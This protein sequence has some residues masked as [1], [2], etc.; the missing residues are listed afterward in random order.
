MVGLIPLFATEVVDQ[1]LLANVPRFR[2][3]LREHKGGSF[4]GQLRL[5]LSGL[6]ERARRAPAGA[7][8]PHHAAA[9]PRAPARRGRVPVALR[10]PQRQP[11][12]RRAPRP[13]RPAGDRPGDDRVR[14]GRVELT[15]VRRQ[16]QLARAD[17]DAGQLHPD[18][19]DREVPP[20]PR[21]RL[22]GG[23]A[24]PWRTRTQSQGDR[25]ADRRT[26]GRHLP[27]R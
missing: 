5:R 20:L 24:V 19:G 12:P 22:Q 26:P 6:G 25:D 23:G 3:R 18:P 10:H 21:R 8:R 17:L 4:P 2:Q 9:D 1:R 13:R 14:A 7:G 11:R 27:P 16:L 15:A